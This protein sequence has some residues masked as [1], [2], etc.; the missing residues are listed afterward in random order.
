M[1]NFESCTIKIE[2]D[3]DED[4]KRKNEIEGPSNGKKKLKMQVKENKVTTSSRGKRKLENSEEKNP[5]KV[6]KI[7]DSEV[8][9]AN[10]I[11]KEKERNLKEKPLNESRTSNESKFANATEKYS[12]HNKITKIKD[13]NLVTES[14]A[15]KENAIEINVS[16]KES[17]S[18]SND[19]NEKN[20][21]SKIKEKEHYLGLRKK[22]K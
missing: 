7:D 9:W 20:R 22:I 13:K 15:G 5:K 18:E 1:E 8:K 16:D 6:K 21:N 3:I 2:K 19:E 4:R 10:S 14:E 17:D 12:Y 11:G